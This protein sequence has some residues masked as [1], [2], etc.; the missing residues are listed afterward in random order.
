MDTVFGYPG[1][2]INGLLAAWGWAANQPRFV[3]A[4]HEEMA[5]FEAVGYAKFTG[6]L[7]VCVATSGPPSS[8]GSGSRGD[9]H[10]PAPTD[11][12]V[13][14]SVHTALVTLIVR[15]AGPKRPISS[16]RTSGDTSR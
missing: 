5:A 16:V 6:R 15:H 11:P 13:N 7:G 2:R 3:Q 12:Y 14:L 4:R 1:D 8:R 10:P 9:S